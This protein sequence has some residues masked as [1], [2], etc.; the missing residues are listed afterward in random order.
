M[1]MLTVALAVLAAAVFAAPFPASALGPP[2]NDSATS[3]KAILALPFADSIDTSA[4]TSGPED[5]SVCGLL[6]HTVWYTYN[7]GPTGNDH[8]YLTANRASA[9]PYSM[10]VLEGSPTGKVVGCAGN[11]ASF[12]AKPSVTYYIVVGNTPLDPRPRLDFKATQGVFFTGTV[13]AS[14]FDPKSGAVALTGSYGCNLP[15]LVGGIEVA[16]LQP[17]GRF[18]ITAGPSH[19]WLGSHCTPGVRYPWSILA[20]GDNGKFKGGT[21]TA[22]VKITGQQDGFT[23]A[24]ETFLGPFALHLTRLPQH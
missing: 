21:A 1:R 16:V 4:A 14:K 11:S 2:P 17:V 24:W 7:A 10:I 8:V 20:S 22:H 19:L 18:T 5:P 3:A 13:E 12:V 6:A 15:S 23:Y 9:P